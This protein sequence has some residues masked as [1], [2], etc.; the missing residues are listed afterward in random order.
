MKAILLLTAI[1]FFSQSCTKEDFASQTEE[2]SANRIGYDFQ[3][4]IQSVYF[5]NWI[6]GVRGGGSGTNF[7]MG[8]KE[9]LPEGVVLS[10]LYFRG[11]KAPVIALSKFSYTANFS[12]N[13]VNPNDNPSSGADTGKTAM[14]VAEP[15]FPIEDD[16]ALLEYY[17]NQELSYY[18]LTKV[19]EKELVF[20]PE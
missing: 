16:Q 5:E 18:L 10:Q 2:Q 12:D 8:F 15:P 4:N 3:A 13:G 14:L 6:S 20:L 7:F 1:L 17:D 19:E 9:P 11:K